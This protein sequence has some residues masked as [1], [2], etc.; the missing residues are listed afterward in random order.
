MNDNDMIKYKNCLTR[1]RDH[2]KH[3]ITIDDCKNCDNH[4]PDD[5]FEECSAE[6]NG[7]KL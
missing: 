7:V 6:M 4:L 5:I 1:L 3:C 2:P